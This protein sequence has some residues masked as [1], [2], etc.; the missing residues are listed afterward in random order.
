M[1]SYFCMKANVALMA[2]TQESLCEAKLFAELPREIFR[3]IDLDLTCINYKIYNYV[4]C[5]CHTRRFGHHNNSPNVLETVAPSVTKA[6]SNPVHLAETCTTEGEEAGGAHEG[7]QQEAEEKV[8]L[9]KPRCS[10]G[11]TLKAGML[12]N[13]QKKE[14]KKER[15]GGRGEGERGRE[16]ERRRGGMKAGGICAS[17]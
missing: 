7:T 6:V 9:A 14:R 13:G 5:H 4:I 1:F 11:L 8:G 15:R 16:G 2:E 10:L 17:L 3:Q 12:S